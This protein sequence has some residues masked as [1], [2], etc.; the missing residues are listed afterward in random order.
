[1]TVPVPTTPRDLINLSL[2][3]ANV[4]GV[5]QVASA[6]D[7]ND[8]FNLL[9]MLMAQLQRRRYMIYQLVTLAKQATGAISYTVG[10][11]GDFN[12]ARPAKLESAFFR[13]NVQTPLPVD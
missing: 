3:T 1:M 8:A 13:Q 6:E 5:G 12:V 4:L 9:N 7:M 11:G 10:P 2:K